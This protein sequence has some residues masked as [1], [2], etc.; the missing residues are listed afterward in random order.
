MPKIETIA[1]LIPVLLLSRSLCQDIVSDGCLE[2]T[3][4][5]CARCSRETHL[6]EGICYSNILGCLEYRDGAFCARC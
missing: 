5:E 3:A 1:I 4:G 2:F 6:Y